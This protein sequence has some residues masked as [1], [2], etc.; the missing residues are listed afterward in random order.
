MTSPNFKAFLVVFTAIVLL[1]MQGCAEFSAFKS[2]V[3]EH[4]ADASDQVLESALWT[5]C[6]GV[7]VGAVKRRFK[8]EQERAAYNDLCPVIELP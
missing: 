3:A 1:M 8:T 6:T 2:G 4:G 5:V 7:S